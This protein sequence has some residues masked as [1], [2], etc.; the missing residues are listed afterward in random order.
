MHMRTTIA[1]SA[2]VG[3]LLLA[4]CG[5]DAD[6][7]STTS[8][9]PDGPST[10]I[11]RD[12]PATTESEPGG[13]ATAADTT[14]G[15]SVAAHIEPAGEVSGGAVSRSYTAATY[16]AGLEAIIAAAK[17]DLA[18]SLGID[19]AAIDVALVEEVVWSDASLGCPQ[20]GMRYRQVPTDGMRIV[21]SAG[22]VSYDY[23][24]DG[25]R[26]PFLCV[27]APVTK[28]G[29]PLVEIREDGSVV[30]I[31]PPPPKDGLPTETITPPGD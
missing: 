2:T 24:S 27:H 9:D 28:E 25:L 21:L 22:D 29:T 23:R 4:A 6:A 7:G 5:T 31:A 14:E 20:P 26:D 3:L 18:T 1:V 17:A 10:I 19:E 11:E 8:P 13:P 15:S 30:T 12:A 16:P